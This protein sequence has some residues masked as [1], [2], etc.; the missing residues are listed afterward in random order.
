MYIYIYIYI[1]IYKY[2]YTHKH[3]HTYTHLAAIIYH[4]RRRCRR[5]SRGARRISSQG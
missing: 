2:I 1:Y 5:S 4:A 3:T